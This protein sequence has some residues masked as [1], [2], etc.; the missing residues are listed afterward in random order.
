[1]YEA[2]GYNSNYVYLEQNAQ[3][4]PNGLVRLQHDCHVFEAAVL[5]VDA[6]QHIKVAQSVCGG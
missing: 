3:T 5:G 2:T 6:A 1:M 4:L